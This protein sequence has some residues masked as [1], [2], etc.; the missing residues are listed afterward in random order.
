VT[1]PRAAVLFDVDGTLVDT[2]YQHVLAWQE[3]FAV[4]A[5]LHVPAAV[6]HRAVG[7]GSDRYVEHILGHDDDAVR[8]AH[9]NFYLPNLERLRPFPAAGEL[10]AAV[11]R[12]GASVVLATSAS[13]TEADRLAEALGAADAVDAVV[14]RDDVDSSKPSPDVVATA[15]DR[16]GSDARSAVF[17]GDTVWDVQAA[18]RAGL[19]CVAVCCGGISEPE[20]R[21]AGAVAVYRDPEHLLADLAESPLARVA[22]AGGVR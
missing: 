6:L 1:R 12:L 5:G 3:A 7:L 20:L 14:C 19:D 9:G 10:L 2:N 11:A 13:R 22:D 18:G 21:A 15:L 16:A 17:V 4:A 8:R